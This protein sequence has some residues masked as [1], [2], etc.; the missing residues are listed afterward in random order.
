MLSL[1][2]AASN[3]SLNAELRL[4]NIFGDGMV[5]Q[6]GK[7]AA[8]WGWAAPGEEVKVTFSEQE[9]AA[10]ADA[11][12]RWLARL[13][14]M[15]ANARGATLDVAAGDERRRVADVLVGDVWICGGQSNMEWSML[16]LIH[17]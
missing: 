8:I 12:G 10:R 7:P 1:A 17:I 16:S 13:A 6:R 14:P 5:L 11:E 15:K 9:A 2:L 4:P 3:Q